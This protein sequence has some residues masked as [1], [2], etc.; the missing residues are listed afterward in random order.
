MALE[1]EGGSRLPAAKEESPPFLSINNDGA[2]TRGSVQELCKM[3]YLPSPGRSDPGA[4][5]TKRG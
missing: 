5:P 2:F 4:L 1:R 3:S